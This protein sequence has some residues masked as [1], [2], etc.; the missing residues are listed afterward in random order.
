MARGDAHLCQCTD[1]HHP[2]PP[3]REKRESRR[4]EVRGSRA[5]R[6]RYR[7]TRFYVKGETQTHGEIRK[8]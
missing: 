6:D 7:D 2:T 1:A 4:K 3:A 8:R 5:G